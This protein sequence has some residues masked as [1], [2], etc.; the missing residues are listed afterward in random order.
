MVIIIYISSV[1]D[2]ESI[3][4]VL[5]SATSLIKEQIS[6]QRDCYGIIAI[7][8]RELLSTSGGSG[9]LLS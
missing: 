5:L 3:I 4:F 9:F 8:Q 1:Y 6:I 7:Y 2:M